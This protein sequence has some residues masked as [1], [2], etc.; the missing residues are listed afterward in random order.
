MVCLIP[1]D[2]MKKMEESIDFTYRHPK[3]HVFSSWVGPHGNSTCEF[4]RTLLL[5]SRRAR[6]TH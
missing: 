3:D 5:I 4:P 1:R 6:L 2:G